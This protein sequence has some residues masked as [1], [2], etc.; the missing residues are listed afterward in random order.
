M[1]EALQFFHFLRPFWLLA[2]PLIALMWW[3][4]R[5]R[6][7]T[8]PALPD[9]IA[10]HLAEA[11]QVGADGK[12][13]L[14][15]NDGV[16]LGLVLLALAVAGPTWSRIPN[17][18]LADTAPLV[19]AI[20]VTDSM[21][22]TDL[23][24]TRLDRARFKVLDLITARAGARTGLIAYSG[25]AHNVSPLTEDP[26]ILRPLLE[27][28]S[29]QVMPRDGADAGAALVLAAEVLQGADTAG[30]TA[31]AV[32]FVLDDMDPADIAAFNEKTDPPRPPVLFLLTLP[33]GSEVAQLDRVD[34]ASVIHLTADDRDV[35]QI[36]RRVRAAYV[37]ALAGDE[38]LQWD[39]RGWM[40]SI[41][42]A[43]LVLLW[44]RRGWTMR[45]GFVGLMLLMTPGQ[46][47][48]EGW[49]DWF[50]TPD[51]QGQIAFNN[52]GFARAADLFDDPY[53]R[54]ISMQKAGQ[55]AEASE[56]LA[57]ISTAEAAFAQGYAHIRNREYRPAIR[58]YETALER[59]PDYP[60]AETN[61]EI[62]QAILVTVED[63][64]EASDTGEESGIGADDVVFDNEDARGTVTE[65]EAPQEDAAPL[66]AEQW[67]SGIDT[68]MGDFLRSRFLLENEVRK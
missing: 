23:A 40:L 48:A 35:A 58:A 27:G 66:T 28:L 17:P 5:P 31:G 44:F 18:L 64:R 6:R 32:L 36:E 43:L 25:S 24:P 21:M 38:R 68:D 60:E 34:G 65:I 26:N 61:L 55:Y 50:A 67:M 45:W 12:A 2:V 39:D 54:G 10:P 1:S 20:K 57:R 15:P 14:L 8:A 59:R 16:A 47:R 52:K 42:A 9:M 29:P 22:E 63:A 53:R 11:L 41:L 19:V 13:R 51:Q 7:G 49:K 3:L 37:A 30:E 56:M 46:A 4:I 62:A 33:E